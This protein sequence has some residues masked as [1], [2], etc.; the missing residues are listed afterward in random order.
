[1]DL[2]FSK[3]SKYTRVDVS[4]LVDEYINHSE[5]DRYLFEDTLACCASVFRKYSQELF[6]DLDKL[7]VD[8]LKKLVV[9]T[10]KLDKHIT[11]DNFQNNL[12]SVSQL[13]SYIKK[14]DAKWNPGKHL[15]FNGYAIFPMKRSSHALQLL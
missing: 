1:M 10:L 3:I 6:Y 11:K 12:A 8:G 14:K 7:L 2:L 5:I 13:Y 15:W 9:S 4:W